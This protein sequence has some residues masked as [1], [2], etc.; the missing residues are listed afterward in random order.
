MNLTS[1]LDRTLNVVLLTISILFLLSVG[2]SASQAL[3]PGSVPT[4]IWLPHMIWNS[5]AFE[6]DAAG[7]ISQHSRGVLSAWGRGGGEGFLARLLVALRGCTW[8]IIDLSG[9]K[10]QHSHVCE[11]SDCY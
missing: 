8:Q 7:T 4:A 1:H 6:G 9:K 2:A 5:H 10:W 11:C 3:H